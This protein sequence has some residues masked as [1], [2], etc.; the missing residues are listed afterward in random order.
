MQNFAPEIK[1]L[2]RAD[3]LSHSE[4]LAVLKEQYAG[5]LFA[6]AGEGVY[7]C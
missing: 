1:T 7:S 3:E 4:T 2:N 6:K 5:Y